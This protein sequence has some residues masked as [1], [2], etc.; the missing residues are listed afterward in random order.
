LRDPTE[1]FIHTVA[2][3]PLWRRLGVGTALFQN[4]ESDSRATEAGCHC[5][6]TALPLVDFQHRDSALVVQKFFRAHE[7]ELEPQVAG[8]VLG[9]RD[10]REVE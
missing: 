1:T 2:V 10:L 3:L 6:N 9:R 7:Y 5:L 4:F 8:W